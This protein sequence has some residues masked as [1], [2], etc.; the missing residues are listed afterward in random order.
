MK[1][2]ESTA[3]ARAIIPSDRVLAKRQRR[4]DEWSRSFSALT[5]EYDPKRDDFSLKM[6]S[7]IQLRI[8]RAIIREFNG[9]LPKTL[10]KVAV[11]IGGDSIESAVLDVHIFLPGL[12]RDLFGLNLGQRIGGHTKSPAKTRAARQN[13]RLGGRPPAAKKRSAKTR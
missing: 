8:P 3:K 6:I 7:G 1:A 13:G 10:A 12:L 11:G 2:V 5:I 4:A 9:A